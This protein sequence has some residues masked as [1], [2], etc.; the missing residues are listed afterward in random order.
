MNCG[1]ESAN[2]HPVGFWIRTSTLSEFCEGVTVCELYL[3]GIVLLATSFRPAFGLMF[4]FGD[5]PFGRFLS[6]TPT[7]GSVLCPNGGVESWSL[8]STGV[9][10]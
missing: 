3:L 1:S 6:G 2:R 5:N 10:T 8:L 7:S 9:E 4:L